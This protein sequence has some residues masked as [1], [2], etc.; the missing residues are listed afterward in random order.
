MAYEAAAEA[1]SKEGSGFDTVVGAL[2]KKD[3]LQLI[4]VWEHGASDLD[5][6]SLN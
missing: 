2:M 4:I 3:M 6:L 5:N 1:A